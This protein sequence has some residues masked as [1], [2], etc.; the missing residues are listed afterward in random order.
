MSEFCR[1][2]WEHPDNCRYYEVTLSQDLFGDWCLRQLWGRK[3]SR[4]G[5]VRQRL[6]ES[7]EAGQGVIAAIDKRRHR[8][9]YVLTLQRG[10]TIWE[11]SR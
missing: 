1:L 8:H 3:G 10:T 2:R 5:Q 6:V 7:F 4:L 11:V 9:Q